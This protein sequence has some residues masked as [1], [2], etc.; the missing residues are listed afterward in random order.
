LNDDNL[1]FSLIKNGSKINLADE[2]LGTTRV[3]P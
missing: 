1:T 2:G 3:I